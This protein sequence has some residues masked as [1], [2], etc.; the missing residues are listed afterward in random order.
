YEERS[1][2]IDMIVQQRKTCDGF[3]DFI[4]DSN[5]SIVVRSMIAVNDN[6]SL[7][8]RPS[9]IIFSVAAHQSITAPQPKKFMR[10]SETP[11]LM[12]III[13][14]AIADSPP[15]KFPVPYFTT[16]CTDVV[17]EGSKDLEMYGLLFLLLLSVKNLQQHCTNVQ[18]IKSQIH[19]DL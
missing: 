17:T 1:D 3:D 6:T 14:T 12:M 16:S 13:I 4:T 7:A 18:S 9:F 2:Y 8:Q 5:P 11:S 10:R 19:R 15:M